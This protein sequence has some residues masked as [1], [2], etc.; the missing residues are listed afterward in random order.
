MF[1]LALLNGIVA[2]MNRQSGNI[3]IWNEPG[4]TLTFNAAG[5]I[6]TTV[7]EEVAGKPN[8]RM[9]IASLGTPYPTIM[10]ILK[11]SQ[12]LQKR[13]HESARTVEVQEMFSAMNVC[14]LIMN[15]F[16]RC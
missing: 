11:N 8:D 12:L 3:A 5:A 9:S 10:G 2:S 15:S 4:V 14:W 13:L 16:H 7:T 6:Q 1:I